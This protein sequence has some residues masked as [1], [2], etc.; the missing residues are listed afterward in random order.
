[1]LRLDKKSSTTGFTPEPELAFN[2]CGVSAM[3][4]IRE[5]RCE[6]EGARGGGKKKMWSM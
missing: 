5:A 2:T 6:K 4:V 3:V 1:M